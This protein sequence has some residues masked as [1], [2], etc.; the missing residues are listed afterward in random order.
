MIIKQLFII[1][2]ALFAGFIISSAFHLPIP[3]NVLGLILL[4]TALCIGLIKLE[5]V[6][7]ISDFIIKY[8][9]VFFV[10]PTVGIMVNFHILSKEFVKIMVPL[11]LSVLIGFFVAGKATELCIRWREKSGREKNA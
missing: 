3:A 9:A 6:E 11:I 8:L 2:S 1:L 7:Q 4:F 5:H 10:V